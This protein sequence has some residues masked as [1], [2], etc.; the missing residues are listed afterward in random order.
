[1]PL[2][3]ESEVRQYLLDEIRTRLIGPVT[4]EE[5]IGDLPTD[6]YLG[7]I[8]Y[9]QDTRFDP[10]DDD[11][12]NEIALDEETED[13][14]P[15]PSLA[16]SLRPSSI[17]LTCEIESTTRK[18]LLNVSFGTYSPIHE[19][20]R[21]YPKWKRVPHQFDATIDLEA[22]PEPLDIQPCVRVQWTIDLRPHRRSRVLSLF[23][24]NT[25]KQDDIDKHVFQPR[26]TLKGRDDGRPFVQRNYALFPGTTR[27]SEDLSFELLFRDK[28]EFAVGHGVSVEWDS[29]S[30]ENR[31]K[32]WTE[33]IP[34]HEA[35]RLDA[36]TFSME[37]LDLK[38]LVDESSPANLRNLLNPLPDLYDKWIKETEAKIPSLP[39]NFRQRAS[40]HMGRCRESLNRMR[41]GIDVVCKE[42]DAFEAFQ[43]ANRV[44]LLQL[45]RIPWVL[46]FRRTRQRKPVPPLAA[47][48]RPF[49]LA[50]ILTC[51]RG[52]VDPR[53]E[54]R[55]I[56]DLL[57]FPT[58]G[59]KTEAYLALAAFAMAHRR[60]SATR[61]AT[62]GAGVAIIMRY[63]LRLL[64]VQQFQRAAMM[65]CACEIIRR[66]EKTK[67]GA[68]PFSVGLWVGQTLTPN[69]FDEA[70]RILQTRQNRRR[71]EGTP[72]QLH[73]CP[74][75]GENLGPKN[76]WADSSRRWILV[77]CGR[78]ECEFHGK[79]ADK[80]L[81]VMTVDED[82]YKRCPSLVIATVDKFARIAWNHRT[83]AIFG[84]VNRYCPRHGYLVPADS[85]PDSHEGSE[86]TKAV[87]VRP[88]LRLPPPSLIIQDELH[89]I[90][91]PLGTMVGLYETA[92]DYL[93]SWRDRDAIVPAKVVASTA[94]I[95]RAGDQ[96]YKLFS[97]STNQFPHPGIDAGD[98]FFAKEIPLQDRSGRLFVGVCV[99]GRSVKFA[100]V[101][102]VA[103]LL[104][105]AQFQRIRKAPIDAFWTL[106]GYFNSLRELGGA[107]R[108]T[109]DDIPKRMEYIAQKNAVREIRVTEELTSRMGSASIPAILSMLDQEVNSPHCI[110]ILLATN[111][112]SVGV[113]VQRLG[114]MV[115]N[116]QPKGTSEYLQATSRVG[117]RYPGLIVT[118][119]NWFKARDMSHYERFVPYHSMLYRH[120]DVAS[121]TPFAPRARDRG[122]KAL[123]IGLARILDPRLMTNQGASQFDPSLPVVSQI[124]E[125][126][127]KRAESLE[128]KEATRVRQEISNAID[129]WEDL[130]E[131]YGNKLVYRLPLGGNPSN[132]HPL[133]RHV[134]DV[135]PDDSWKT[136]DSLRNVERMA[137]LFYREAT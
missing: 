126:L 57:W 78:S 35:P 84:R 3:S 16:Q 12:H 49:Q 77:S 54:D 117:R 90:S 81:P 42:R 51:L 62:E 102:L 68:E 86:T 63:T 37:G 27:E 122:L 101:W 69:D 34:F 28:Y 15:A 72:V 52:I 125:I 31:S 53:S 89:L 36:F 131:E 85:H 40:E 105:G 24:L 56:V 13:S 75:C 111:M 10:A 20:G 132:Y 39:S 71:V 82:I 134:E 133:L 99:P 92:I 46:D 64:T 29:V 118:L 58:G 33:L 17:G 107:L 83:A 1:M 38:R 79:A 116:G 74:W 113:D 121:V 66:Q 41:D 128:P 6:N 65:L 43:F 110:D 60:L 73:Y 103:S 44:M 48:W 45:S 9:P 5:E 19:E 98:S 7:G 91:G 100:L 11:A 23:L 80:S 104:Q 130:V 32:I 137:N 119:Y 88:L 59:G 112:L 115:V 67:W 26:I 8:L 120:V 123:I 4:D 70:S 47:S 127:E 21:K 25:S 106:V 87:K 50:F 136:P 94:T 18:I 30:G 135:A 61:T 76:Y 129:L 95:S 14:E 97:R 2:A 108:L 22:T 96:V 124:R 93:C 114:L 55:K 109:E